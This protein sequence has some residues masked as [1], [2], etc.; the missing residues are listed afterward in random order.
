MQA[1]HP[2]YTQMYQQTPS[3]ATILQALQMDVS[4]TTNGRVIS[5]LNESFS[6]FRSILHFH[7][8]DNDLSR[9]AVD[10]IL[11]LLFFSNLECFFEHDIHDINMTLT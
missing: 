6:H 7:I 8:L 9:A 5:L 4:H 3:G 11:F 10:K 2:A 1:A